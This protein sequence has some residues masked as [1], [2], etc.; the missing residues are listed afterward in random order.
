MRGR[1]AAASGLGTLEA[2]ETV[3]HQPL[4]RR[5]SKRH[6]AGIDGLPGHALLHR[7]IDPYGHLLAAHDNDAD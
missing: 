2:K 6:L 1:G 7:A 3:V 4:S 5:E